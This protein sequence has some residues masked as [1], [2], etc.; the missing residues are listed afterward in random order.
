[1]NQYKL[2]VIVNLVFG[3]LLVVFAQVI[4]PVCESMGGVTM[5]CGTSV[6]IESVLGIALLATAVVGAAIARK[7]VH[8]V[9]SAVVTV[10]G[11]FVSLVP[12]IIVGTCPH[13]HMA[14]HAVTAPV[15]ALTGTVIALFSVVNIVVLK[16]KRRNEQDWY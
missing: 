4:L 14:C 6:N 5:R 9:L 15:F 2:F 12:T 1:M 8:L 11:V 16:L 13:I 10:I 3:V 7:K